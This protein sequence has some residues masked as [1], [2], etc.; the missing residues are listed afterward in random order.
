MTSNV[1]TLAQPVQVDHR[2]ALLAAVD[3]YELPRLYHTQVM[4][5][6]F[7]RPE[8]KDLGGG[9]KLYLSDK[10]RDED[11]YQSKAGLII[12]LGPLAGRNPN[13]NFNWG[14]ELGPDGNYLPGLKVGDWVMYRASDGAQFNLGGPNGVPCKILLDESIKAGLDDPEQVW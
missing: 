10:S 8:A 4:V 12:A 14:N 5:A 1:T 6:T 9:K 13:G 3:S 11:R 2:A 7:I